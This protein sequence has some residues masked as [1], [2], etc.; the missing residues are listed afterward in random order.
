M[1]DRKFADHFAQDWINA[2]NSHDLDRILSHYT[3]DFE[4]SSPVIIRITGESSGTLKGKEKVG[5]YW[6]QALQRIPDLHFDLLATL[7]GVESIT[8][9]YKGARGLSAE[10]FHFNQAGMVTK[11][12]AH[13]TQD[14]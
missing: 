14:P 3:D 2:W 4:M 5:A 11:A 6:V 8:L 1:L 10:V 12:Y 9:Y 7:V 13:Y